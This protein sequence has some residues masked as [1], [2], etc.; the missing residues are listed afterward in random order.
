MHSSQSVI[1]Q[2]QTIKT[3]I[4][5]PV[6]LGVK[7][8]CEKFP[9]IKETTLRW[10]IHTKAALGISDVFIKPFGQR[11]IL[12]DVKRYFQLMRELGR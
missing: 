3:Q 11:M 10:Q 8:F 1:N 2:D 12:V 9:F 4:E 5:V 7:E 6:Y